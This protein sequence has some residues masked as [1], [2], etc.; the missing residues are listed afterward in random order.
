MTMIVI[1]M[2]EV[3]C[4]KSSFH[5]SFTPGFS[6]V[7]TRPGF[8]WKPFKRFPLNF[9]VRDTWLKPGVNETTSSLLLKRHFEAKHERGEYHHD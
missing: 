5:F 9:E 8:D 2:Y 6:Q 1:T 4:L 7:I 3:L